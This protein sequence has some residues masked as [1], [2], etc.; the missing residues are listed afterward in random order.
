MTNTPKALISIGV[1]WRFDW[2]ISVAS[3][4]ALLDCAIGWV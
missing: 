1:E 4:Q 2:S 3:T